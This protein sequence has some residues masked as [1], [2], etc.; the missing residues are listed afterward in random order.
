MSFPN[1]YTQFK[2]GESGNPSGKPQGTIHLSTHIAKLMADQKFEANIFDSKVGIKEYKGA[3]ITAIIQVAINKA[4]AG[5]DKAR[6]WL[7]KYGWGT[8]QEIQHSGEI[9]TGIA[10]PET[11][12][13]FA[14][15]MKDKTKQ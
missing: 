8:K 5:D 15:F 10:D 2:P 7:A 4:V 14:E 1:V 13:Q 12:A 9:S 11:A 3:P 6:E